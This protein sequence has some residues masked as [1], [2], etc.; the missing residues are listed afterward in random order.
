MGG[1]WSPGLPRTNLYHRGNSRGAHG[2]D[3]CRPAA[4][5]VENRRNAVR[6][7]RA[8]GD[9]RITVMRIL[10]ELP[11]AAVDVLWADLELGAVPFPLEVRGRG[12]TVDDRARIRQAVY[13]DL[14]RRE[15][16]HTERP[17]QRLRDALR[18]LAA[19]EV[20]VDLVARADADGGKRVMAVVAVRG[21]Q[22]LRAVQREL[23]IE[24][25]EV[26]TTAIVPAIVELMPA[27]RPGP[28]RSVT[29][30]VAALAS[31]GR[32][33]RSPAGLAHRVELGLITSVV[34]RPVRRIGQLGVMVRNGDGAPRR[35]PGIA[36]FDTDQGRYASIVHPGGDG[37]DWT[38]LMPVDNARMA[39]RLADALASASRRWQ[40]PRGGG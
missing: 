37:E 38:T 2:D 19:P 10:A 34:R 14:A 36:W 4:G 22:A 18:V 6:T 26:R 35:L 13:A 12:D 1:G 16:A 25:T 17:T 7:N 40:G 39:H 27:G 29:L 33:G 21:Q 11:I 8:A 3:R 24:L 30:P 31:G 9:R 32:P 23:T 15:L 20:S 28:G 5:S